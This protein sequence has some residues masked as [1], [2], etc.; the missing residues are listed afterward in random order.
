MPEII[1]LNLSEAAG[2]EACLWQLTRLLEAAGLEGVRVQSGS[3]APP[4]D[5]L[6]RARLARADLVITVG[7]AGPSRTDTAPEALA[8]VC[9]RLLP[10]LSEAMRRGLSPEEAPLFRG[11]AGLLGNTLFLNLPEG[12]EAVC[13][14][15]AALPA[16]IHLLWRRAS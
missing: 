1:L 14:L 12:P 5:A 15:R 6:R 4:E 11:L 3:P 9:E 10:G 8:A 2:T 16:V 13:V 7:R